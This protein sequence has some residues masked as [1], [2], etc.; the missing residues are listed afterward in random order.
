VH[1]SGDNHQDIL[2]SQPFE[3]FVL[4]RAG[5]NSRLKEADFVRAKNEKID[6]LTYIRK[7]IIDRAK[8]PKPG[9]SRS[10]SRSRTL[11]VSANW[12]RDST[13]TSQP[14][15]E[16]KHAA[17]VNRTLVRLFLKLPGVTIKHFQDKMELLRGFQDALNGK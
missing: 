11:A 13:P 7:D 17:L 14:N 6:T 12:E 3:A 4:E 10:Q 2:S 16:D 9:T 15:I 1:A 8:S 5:L